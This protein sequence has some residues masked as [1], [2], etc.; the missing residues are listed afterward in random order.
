MKFSF[1]VGDAEKHTVDFFWNQMNGVLEIKINGEIVQKG[2]ITLF[3][4]T[5]LTGNLDVPATEKWNLHGYE[6]QLIEKWNFEVG[7]IEKRFVKIEKERA[8]WLAGFRPHKYRVYVDDH[9]IKEYKGY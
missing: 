6:I 4:P 8:K 7:I 5:N 1:E 3:S 9:L 2:S